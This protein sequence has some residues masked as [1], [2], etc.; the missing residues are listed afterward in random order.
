MKEKIAFS[1]ATNHSL[2]NSN[3]LTYTFATIMPPAEVVPEGIRLHLSK[4]WVE[5]FHIVHVGMT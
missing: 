2:S 3:D 1:S 5:N 4:L